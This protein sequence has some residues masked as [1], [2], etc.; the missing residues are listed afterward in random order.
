MAV[1]G[2]EANAKQEAQ[3]DEL[4]ML[5]ANMAIERQ[6]VAKEVKEF[7]AGE[8]AAAMVSVG[9][10]VTEEVAVAM[11]GVGDMVAEEVA[12]AMVGVVA[13]VEGIV[14]TKV[15]SAISTMDSGFEGL[16]AQ[17]QAQSDSNAAS[18]QKLV[19]MMMSMQSGAGN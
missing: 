14:D 4:K 2:D 18:F 17:A 1:C 10:L 5:L 7:V 19:T 13:T 12:A 3:I 16:R 9:E 11:A 8:V 15:S 6:P